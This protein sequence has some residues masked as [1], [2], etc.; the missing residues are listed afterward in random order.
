MVASGE[1][2]IAAVDAPVLQEYMV[3]PDAVRLTDAPEQMIASL[4]AIPDVSATIMGT[5]GIEFT[6]PLTATFWAVAPAE[7]QTI[8]PDGVPDAEALSRT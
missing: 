2:L 7:L 6:V 3:P 1:T 5:E 4:F 8:F